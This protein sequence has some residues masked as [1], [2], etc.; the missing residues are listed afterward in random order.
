L[1]FGGFQPRKETLLSNKK[2][3][4]RDLAERLRRNSPATLD[5]VTAQTDEEFESAFETILAQVL[6]SLEQDSKNLFQLNE[7]GLSSILVL[8]FN[9]AGL[10]ASRETNSNGHVDLTIDI[11]FCKTM[12]RKLGEAKIYNGPSYHIKGLQQLIGRYSTGR[13]TRGL[14]IEYVKEANILGLIKKIR[15]KM[16]TNK[17]MRQRG[18]TLD[19]GLKW[20]FLSI[21]RHSSGED[22]QVGHYGCNLFNT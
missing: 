17:P 21:H 22:L 14:I 3:N 19:N 11:G 9:M 6:L 18:K 8:A 5:I 10:K 7:D 4:V 1:R 13:E 12:R 2:G 16:D 20:S 15:K